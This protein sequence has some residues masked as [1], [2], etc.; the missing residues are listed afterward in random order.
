MPEIEKFFLEHF[1]MA[2]SAQNLRE[3]WS[4]ISRFQM[5]MFATIS[6]QKQL[7]RT[8]GINARSDCYNVIKKYIQAES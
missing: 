4:A 7:K 6:L 2:F 8:E 1:E 3:Y 5:K